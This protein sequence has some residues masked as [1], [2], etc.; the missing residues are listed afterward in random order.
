MADHFT[1]I[2]V[3]ARHSELPD[4]HRMLA[5]HAN[6]FGI[7]AD[8]VLRLQL[9]AEELFINTI[10][11]GY[12]GDSDASIHLSLTRNGNALHLCYEDKAP[13]FDPTRT[14][15]KQEAASDIGGLG[16][17]LIRGMCKKVRY[18]RR[19]DSNVIDIDL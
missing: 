8:D 12:R 4:L 7:S 14:P 5:E 17:C 15:E 18:E 2:S 1:D 19:N 16:I 3:S 11:H 13:A 10:S 9:L 6:R